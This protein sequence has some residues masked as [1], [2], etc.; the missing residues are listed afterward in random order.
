MTTPSKP[1]RETPPPVANATELNPVADFPDPDDPALFPRLTEAQLEQ[2]AELAEVQSLSAGD[3]L[4]EQGQRDAPFYVI[5]RGSV[6]FFDRRPE[7][8]R[9]FAKCVAGTFVGDLAM[10]T[11]EPTIAACVAAEKTTALVMPREHLRQL[12]AG[13]AD[14]GDL[15]LRTMT[16][17]REWLEGHGFGQIR[18]IGS[19]WSRD[20]F[21][22]RDLLQRNLIPFHWHELETDPE[23]E[24]LLETLGIGAESCPVLVRTDGVLRA[25]T[26]ETVADE[27]G[28]RARV[29]GRAF[30]LVVLGAG[31]AGLAS[32]VYGASEGLSTLVLEQFAPGGQA[33]TSARIE[34]YLGF[35]TGLSGAELTQ[36]ATLQ[37]RK[38]GAVISSAHTGCRFPDPDADEPRLLMLDDGQVVRARTVVLATGADYRRLP[39][40]DA[41][42]FE[43]SGLYYAATHVEALQ[44]DGEAVVVAGGGNSAGQAVVNLARS[45]RTV[46]LVVR[47]ALEATMSRY[48]IDRITS[49]QNVDVWPGSEVKALHGDDELQ[50]VTIADGNATDHRIAVSAVF[51]M[52]GATPRTDGVQTLVGLDDKGFVAT[53]NDAAEHGDFAR[54]WKD[55]DRRPAM[56]ET[57]RRDV[58]AVGDV[59]SGSTKRV[60]SAVGDGA[61]AVRFVHDSLSRPRED[62]R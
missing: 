25:P 23:S 60:A 44:C 22:V 54:H 4:F 53:G 15:I 41:E 17:R 51:A 37:A 27:L 40:H 12:V 49:A 48:L 1:V 21:A 29:N 33:S 47:R 6:D 3:V 56:L 5:Q 61:I 20:A 43:G 42:R 55:G 26:V 16:A 9:Y 10:F 30:D 24:L 18:L 2:V 34:N 36:R 8:D 19:R 31:P 14:L 35:P 57:T 45:A 7:G 39:A 38:F 58:F 59:R 46:H 62:L 28:L 52:I 11:G 13:S 32:A 50:S